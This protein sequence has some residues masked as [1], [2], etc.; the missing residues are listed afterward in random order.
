MSIR[1]WVIRWLSFGDCLIVNA[2]ILRDGTI[3]SNQAGGI[4]IAGNRVTADKAVAISLGK[5]PH[6]AALSVE[7]LRGQTG[8]IVDNHFYCRRG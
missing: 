2:D 1:H 3:R 8:Y 5:T 4:F 6:P 7:V